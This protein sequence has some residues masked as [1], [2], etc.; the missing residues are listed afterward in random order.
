[1]D[2]FYYAFLALIEPLLYLSFNKKVNDLKVGHFYKTKAEFN[3]LEKF[4]SGKHYVLDYLTIAD[5]FVAEF[6]HYIRILYP[7]EF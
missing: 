3:R 1:M 7:D 5:F 2:N 6:S 4:L